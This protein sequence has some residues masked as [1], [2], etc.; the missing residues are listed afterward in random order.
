MPRPSSWRHRVSEIL[1]ALRTLDHSDLERTQI[2]S[3]FCLQRRAAIR[4][5]APFVSGNRNGSWRVQ[6]ERLI[7]WLEGLELE[8]K[9]ERRRHQR[10]LRALRD[11]EDE[12]RSL[13]EEL[14]RKGRP[15]PANW[16]LKRDVL[17]RTVD[18]LPTGIAI[19]PGLVSVSFPAKDPTRGARLLHELSLA[20]LNDWAMFCALAGPPT[21]DTDSH[22]IDGL[23]ERL[24]WQR[25]QAI[26]G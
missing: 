18:A 22:K 14:H 2:E 11:R 10:V 6:R 15:D 26:D 17:A 1:T 25:Q 21:N 16:T 9:E 3:L 4:L 5:M 24:E 12:N 19:S 8:V 20:M 13:R 7:A 23:L